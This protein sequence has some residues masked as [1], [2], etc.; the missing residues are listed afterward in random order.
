VFLIASDCCIGSYAN[1]AADDECQA[2]IVSAKPK[3]WKPSHGF[4]GLDEWLGIIR[5]PILRLQLNK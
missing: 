4:E 3:D 1:T 2:Q 5:K